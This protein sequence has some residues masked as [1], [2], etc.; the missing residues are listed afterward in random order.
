MNEADQMLLMRKC[1]YGANG[2]TSEYTKYGPLELCCR[3]SPMGL[4]QLFL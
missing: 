3:V 4:H 2:I 1:Y